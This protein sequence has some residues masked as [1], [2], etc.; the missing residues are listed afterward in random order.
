MGK[1]LGN[2]MT[3]VVSAVIPTYNRFDLLVQCIDSL[4]GQSIDAVQIIVVDN[5]SPVNL[6]QK[7]AQAYGDRVES[8]RMDRN[9]FYCRAVNQGSLLALAP[10]I[11]V[12]N[13]DCVVRHD[14]AAKVVETFEAH[15]Y[16]G[17][18]ASLV[19]KSSRPGLIDSAGDHLDITGRP[20]NIHHGS[21]SSSVHLTLSPVF[22]AAGSCAAYRRS[23]FMAAGQFDEDFTA[24]L[25][26]I[27]LGFRLQ[28]LG[29]PSVFNPDCQALHHGGATSKRRGYAARLMER[30]MVWNLA[31][32]M[33]SGVLARHAFRIL[34]CQSMPAPLYDGRS[35]VGWVSGKSA[36]VAGTHRM[37]RKRSLIQETRR[38]PDEYIE[39]LLTSRTVLACHL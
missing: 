26:D 30:N 25:D 20:G 38:V 29:W 2:M 22:S 36:A 17:S 16:I 12:V 32:N 34:S 39:D 5:A 19:L 21:L 33:P 7:L 23:A 3:P 28:L 11:A 27:D 4:L 15:P 24:Y 31:K 37:L 8:I 6:N 13:D 35:A 1:V 14:W 18:V 9:Y 10:Y